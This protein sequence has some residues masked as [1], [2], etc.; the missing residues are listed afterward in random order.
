VKL[1]K[2]RAKL[3]NAKTGGDKERVLV[4]VMRIAPWMTEA[5][6]VATTKREKKA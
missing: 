5:E 1:K 6:F 4:K 3:L 2:L